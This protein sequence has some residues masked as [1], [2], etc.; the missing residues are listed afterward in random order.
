[1]QQTNYTKQNGMIVILILLVL[2]LTISAFLLSE[3][4]IDTVRQERA[5]KTNIALAEAKELLLARMLVLADGSVPSEIGTLSCPDTNNDGKSDNAGCGGNQ[6]GRLPYQTLN[7]EQITDGN[8]E[9]LW[10]AMADIFDVNQADN[11][12]YKNLSDPAHQLTLD[13]KPMSIVI[14]S[15]GAVLTGQDR[16]DLGENDITNYFEGDNADGDT[17]FVSQSAANFNDRILGITPE[18]I[19]AHLENYFVK[20]VSN[21]LD[22]FYN[23]NNFYPYPEDTSNSSC[24]S[25]SNMSRLDGFY[26]GKLPSAFDSG[27]PYSDG[28][29]AFDYLND[30][31]NFTNFQQDWAEYVWYAVSGECTQGQDCDAN[32]DEDEDEEEGGGGGDFITF[33]PGGGSVEVQYVFIFS[34]RPFDTSTLPENYCGVPNKN[35]GDEGPDANAIN[36]MQG[37]GGANNLCNYLED[38]NYGRKNA[39]V[40]RTFFPAQPGSNDRVIVKELL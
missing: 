1:M 5:E 30:A 6:E 38:T 37:Y 36:G 17:D 39:N 9:P 10:Y 32:K 15:P 22:N 13:G 24:D 35:N 2:T 8:G 7:S 40:G 27:C 31:I 12:N 16:S 3:F 23:E 14:M 4:N 19:E 28:S 33:N 34:G 20:L 18:E 29:N 11:I 25:D 26:I 21:A